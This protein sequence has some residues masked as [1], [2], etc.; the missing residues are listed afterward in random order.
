VKSLLKF[1]V[2][3]AALAGSLTFAGTALASTFCVP[4][5]SAACKDS[6]INQ[7]EPDLN[8]ALSE[9]GMDGNADTVIIAPGTLTATESFVA[10]G[11]DPLTIKGAGPD[12]TFLTSSSTGNIFVMRL[13]DRPGVKMSDLTLVVPASF[14]DSGGNGSAAQFEDVEFDRVNVEIRNPDSD[15]FSSMLGDNVIRNSRIYPADGIEPGYAFQTNG[16][17]GTTTIIGTSVEAPRYAF[18]ADSKGMRIDVRQ[19]SVANPSLAGV[20]ASGGGTV[21]L[22][23]TLIKTS[24]GAEAVT[25]DTQPN[26]PEG[27]SVSIRSST[28]VHSGAS[29]NPAIELQVPASLTAG[30]ATV[31]VTDSI[32]RGYDHTWTMWVPIG[33]GFPS[34]TLNIDHSNFAPTFPDDS[35]GTANVEGQ[36]N[37]NEDPLFAGPDDFH[38]KPGSPSI[39][40]GDPASTLDTDIEGNVRPVDGDGNGSKLPDQGAYEYQ[41]P[42]CATNAPLC[43][44]DK[45]APRVSKVKFN[46]RR[47]KGG[48]LKMNLSEAATVKAIFT[49]LPR[50]AKHGKKRKVVKLTRRAKAGKLAVKLGK[51]KLSPGRYRLTIRATDSAGNESKPLIRRVKAKG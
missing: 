19:S 14:P 36:G 15:A 32:I 41:P 31:D 9:Y 27:S 28:L 3:V 23:N 42:T 37:I 25:V 4:D 38:L 29:Q 13:E 11:N 8:T 33:P 16:L 10:V 46:F 50:K 18:V 40:T 22:E 20:W 39:D 2:A 51:R 47:G 48:A 43:P 1:A 49:P 7:K 35:N 26:H 24:D 12:K 5:F 21:D 34:A 6:G 44:S 30:D 45:T 17:S